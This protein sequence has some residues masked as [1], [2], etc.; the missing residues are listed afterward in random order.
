[1]SKK[2]LIKSGKNV[3]KREAK[4]A[5]KAILAKIGLS[6]KFKKSLILCVLLSGSMY[7]SLNAYTQGNKDDCA[8]NPNTIKA[9]YYPQ[10]LKNSVKGGYTS[11]GDN[12]NLKIF[13]INLS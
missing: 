10:L 4:E 5:G 13:S 9:A 6:R 12:T 3:A 8:S 1:M 7:Y 2:F 11:I